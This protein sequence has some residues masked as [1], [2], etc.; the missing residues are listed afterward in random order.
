MPIKD[1][2]SGFVGYTKNGFSL[3]CHND[4]FR[5]INQFNDSNIKFLS[6]GLILFS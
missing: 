1:A 4:L 6:V 3:D 2:T 5:R